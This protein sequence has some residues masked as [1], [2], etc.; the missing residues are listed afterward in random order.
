MSRDYLV[1]GVAARLARDLDPHFLLF[2][3][4]GSLLALSGFSDSR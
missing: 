1:F 2:I 4:I 3:G